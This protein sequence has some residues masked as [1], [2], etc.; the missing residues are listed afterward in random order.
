MSRSSLSPP[1]SPSSFTPRTFGCVILFAV[2]RDSLVARYCFAISFSFR[3]AA[4][5][6]ECLHAMR[7]RLS[8]HVLVY[9][10]ASSIDGG[11]SML[12]Q[13]SNG[14]VSPPPYGVLEASTCPPREGS[15]TVRHLRPSLACHTSCHA[16]LSM[17]LHKAA[18]DLLIANAYHAID[19]H[20][21][22]APETDSGTPFEKTI[23]QPGS[24]VCA[25]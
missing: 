8:C 14:R 19:V 16:L 7:Q 5:M 3:E 6:N 24:P 11:E 4:C 21:A 22:A 23:C 2:S 9:S 15:I 18:D 13:R 1:M 17:P 12:S 10:V 20:P 25:D